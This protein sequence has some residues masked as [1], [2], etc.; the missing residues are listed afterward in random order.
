MQR[1][2][3]SCFYENCTAHAPHWLR[4]T[5]VSWSSFSVIL[6]AAAGGATQ[7]V[8]LLRLGWRGVQEYA[9]VFKMFNNMITE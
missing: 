5:I 8:G 9:G 1:G 4:Y 2:F 6:G 3:S 7:W